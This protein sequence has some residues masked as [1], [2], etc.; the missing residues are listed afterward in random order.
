[1]RKRAVIFAVLAFV[2]AGCL[3][4]KDEKKGERYN[5]LVITGELKDL[6]VT[7]PGPPPRGWRVSMDSI[8]P[9]HPHMWDQQSY[10]DV[11][12]AERRLGD[13]IAMDY[14]VDQNYEAYLGRNF[15]VHAPGDTVERRAQLGRAFTHF[16][17]AIQCADSIPVPAQ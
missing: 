3:L 16:R 7:L 5:Y 13:T 14:A 2:L 9:N 4:G 6:V 1:M 10:Y 15:T 8:F 11:C 12:R 17:V